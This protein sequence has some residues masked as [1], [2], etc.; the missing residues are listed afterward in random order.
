MAVE[1][2]E[3]SKVFLIHVDELE[4]AFTQSKSLGIY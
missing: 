1:L 3:S 4:L 2:K